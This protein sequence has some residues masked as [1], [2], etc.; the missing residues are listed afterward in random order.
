MPANN[1]TELSYFQLVTEAKS[2]AAGACPQKLRLALLA[3]CSTQHLVPLLAALFAREGVAVEVYEA[4]YDAIRQEALDAASGLYAFNPQLVVILNDPRA[5]RESFSRSSEGPGAFA[6]QTLRSMTAVWDAIASRSSAPVVQGNLALPYERPFGH[7]DLKAAASFG[8]AVRELNARLAAAARER[9]GVLLLDVDY[10]SGYLGRRRW[11]DQKLWVLCKALCAFDCLPH[12]AK[13]VVELSRPLLGR[14][15]K[16]VV[17]DLDNTL[18]GGVVGDDGLEGIRLGH[19]GEGEAYLELQRFL[20]D[21]KRRGVV[22]AVC[23]RNEESAAREVFRKHPEMLLKED[24][25]SVFVANWT[26]K[27]ENLRAI[28]RALNV[29]FDSMV[30]LDDDAFER[31][32][33]RRELPE[34]IVPELP[35][36]PAEVV[37]ALCELGLFETHS[38][39][40]EDKERARMYAAQAKRESLQ[41]AFKTPEDYLRSLRMKIALAR[42]DA[43]HLPRIAQLLSRS[44]QFN[45]TTKRYAEA[46][47]ERFMKDEAGSFPFYVT[48]CDD[49]GDSG[50]I[51]V[52]I[53]LFKGDVVEIDSWL[54]SCRVLMRGVEEFMMNQVFALARA[55][56]A[57]RVVGRYVPTAKNDMVREF[58]GRFGFERAGEAPEGGV[59]W[60]LDVAGYRERPEHFA[61]RSVAPVHG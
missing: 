30:F 58:Y 31:N 55:R 12:V 44:N 21:L 45:L 28:Q 54:M 29:G 43:F 34:V 32:L 8:F 20:L 52:A 50:L 16:C 14:V 19:L 37:K 46:D 39:S 9:A 60:S 17:V 33:V 11:F 47:C 15:V 13:A 27:A 4:P 41:A 57:K 36:E 35:E 18:W 61:E 25:V 51:A 5:L 23:S 42:F 48:L 3:D 53:L 7:Y 59:V 6:E 56:G 24:D 22:L 2:V 10:L 26:S 38:Y 1:A 40:A 49:L